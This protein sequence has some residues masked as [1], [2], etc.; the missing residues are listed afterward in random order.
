DLACG[1]RHD[2]VGR[3]TGCQVQQQ[4]AHAAFGQRALTVLPREHV[5]LVGLVEP[6]V[7]EARGRREVGLR[8]DEVAH[9]NDLAGGEARKRVGDARGLVDRSDGVEDGHA[10][11]LRVRWYNRSRTAG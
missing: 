5:V 8:R 6:D 11:Y 3:T 1:Q 9:A 7:R 10:S 4:H 2:V